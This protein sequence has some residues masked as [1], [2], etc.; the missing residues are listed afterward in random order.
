MSLHDGEAG[1]AV[2][3]WKNAGRIAAFSEFGRTASRRGGI[4]WATRAPPLLE[5]EV[6][7]PAGVWRGFSLPVCGCLPVGRSPADLAN[8]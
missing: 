4:Y 6:T 3:E 1:V 7:S 5:L 8:L 2:Q